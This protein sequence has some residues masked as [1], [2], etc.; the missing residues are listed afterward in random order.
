[1]HL[2][3]F[4]IGVLFSIRETIAYIFEVPSGIFADQ[5]G[6]KNELMICFIFY[7]LSFFFFFLGGSYLVIVI[8][9]VFFGLGEAFRTGTHK[10][11][12]KVVVSSSL[13]NV[14]FKILQN[15]HRYFLIINYFLT[16]L[17][18]SLKIAKINLK[19]NIFYTNRRKKYEWKSSN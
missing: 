6:K 13:F 12:R 4:Q 15:T 10:P 3:L 11:L 14:I 18:V 16:F 5:Y 17:T 8:A 19:Q 2:N 9:M 7:I 1:V